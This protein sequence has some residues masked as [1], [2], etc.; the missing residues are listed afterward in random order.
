MTSLLE[1]LSVRLATA[2]DIPVIV[3][4]NIALA[5]ESENKRL[6]PSTVLRGVTRG[7]TKGDEVRYLLAVNP[8]GLVAGQ[9]ML[10]REWSD[11]RDGWILWIQSVYVRPEYRSIGVFRR[12]L[13]TAIRDFRA[14][15]DVV[16]MRLYVET[17]NERAQQVYLKTGFEDAHYRVLELM[18][19]NRV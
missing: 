8:E 10:T 2:D 15:P 9:I 14:D 17:G 3:E 7:L 4:Y 18:F 5:W 19:R 1:T 13:E 11:W 16:G 6:D 12:L